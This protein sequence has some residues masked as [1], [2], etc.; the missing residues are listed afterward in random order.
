MRDE[1]K[2]EDEKREIEIKEIGNE[3]KKV[4]EMIDER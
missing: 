2:R 4:G 3:Y 1:M